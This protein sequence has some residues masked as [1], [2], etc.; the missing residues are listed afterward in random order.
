MFAIILQIMDI[1]SESSGVT[2][3]LVTEAVVMIRNPQFY[4]GFC[5][6]DIVFV[7]IFSCDGSFIY[8]VCT[9]AYIRLRHRRFGVGL[10]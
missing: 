7:V 5:T 2:E 8:N 1:R 10:S 9:A 4:I 3:L 6:S